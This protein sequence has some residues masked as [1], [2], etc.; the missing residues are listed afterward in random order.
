LAYS[1]SLPTNTK[2][3]LRYFQKYAI[4]TS[5]PV[6]YGSPFFC[7]FMHNAILGKARLSQGKILIFC[8]KIIK[9]AA[10]GHNISLPV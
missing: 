5:L 8:L 7:Q 2:N 1:I 4:L 9:K 10:G 3:C 6:T